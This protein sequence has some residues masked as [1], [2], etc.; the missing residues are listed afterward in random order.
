MKKNT[1]I[2]LLL[3]QAAVI[4]QVKFDSQF[5]SGNMN[6][7][8]T[9][10]SVNY[11]VTS[12]E[13]IGGRWFYFRITGAKNKFLKVT[14]N[15]SDVNRP[16]YSYDNKEFYR[17]SMMESPKKN[18]FEKTF[19]EDTVYVSYYD[20]YN[21]GSL[22]QKIKQWVKHKDVSLDTLGFTKHSLPIQMLT[23][24]DRSVNDSTKKAIWIHARTHPSETPSSWHLEGIINELLG[25]NEAVEYYK[26]KLIFYIV[27]FTNPDGVYYGRSRTNY[28]GV[29]VE[30]DWGN[31]DAATSKEVSIL[32]QKMA[33]INSR[34]KL[35][36]FL[37]LHS[38]ASPSCT[39]WIHSIISTTAN[40]YLKSH[41]FA[42]LNTSY[43]P[44]FVKADYSES[45]LG[46][47]FPEGWLYKNYGQSVMA[48]T[49]ETPY[50]QYST[51]I[52]VTDQNLF[53]IGSRTLYSIAE[54]LKLSHLRNLLLDNSD[55]V[56][57]GD[58]KPYSTGLE[59]FGSDYIVMDKSV[60]KASLT[61]RT[62]A[63]PAGTYDIDGWW[64]SNP[65]LS[66]S[67][68]FLI[69][70]D[71]NSAVVQKSQ[72]IDGGQW[73]FLKKVSMPNGGII[74]V[75]VNNSDSAPVSADAF[76]IVYKG[77][78]SGVKESIIPEDFVL[79]QNYPNPFNP[80]TTIRYYLNRAGYVKLAVY[81]ILG[82]LVMSV[83]EGMKASGRYEFKFSGR[84][85]SSGVYIYRLSVN[86]IS[87]SKKMM[88]LK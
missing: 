6:G 42:N 7:V 52:W 70:G 78:V 73:N 8:T 24:T 66:T 75:K 87:M 53:E 33:Q 16:F 88:F 60:N 18:Y 51:K 62:Q 56:A 19:E 55:A 76:R 15:N 84:N 64:P 45:N 14:I 48:L 40:F 38:Q 22:Q 80:E 30:S 49:Y 50:D 69:E 1:L 34:G 4:A 85:L 29:D 79:S 27:P 54:Y 2:L 82:K 31:T 10:D 77:Q 68:S 41:Q 28:D 61:Y 37:N 26:Q 59:F 43:N 32:K 58:A 72:R 47:Y 23:I 35:V 65:A 44:Y 57:E 81:D 21:Y 17:F 3:F 5:E 11:F 86:N 12:R 13:D 36:V 71:G 83:D 9:T 20:P 25:S 39:F 63:L 74:T 67:A 46:G